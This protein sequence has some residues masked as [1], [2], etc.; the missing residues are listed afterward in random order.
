MVAPIP[1]EVIR[2]TERLSMRGKR[3][4]FKPALPPEFLLEFFAPFAF[5]AVK[6][7]STNLP[8]WNVSFFALSRAESGTNKKAVKPQKL[9]RLQTN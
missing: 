4:S 9:H 6:F 5:F 2:S 7:P 8:L 1:G 3:A